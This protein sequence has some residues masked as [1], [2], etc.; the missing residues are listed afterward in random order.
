MLG[1]LEYIGQYTNIPI[2]LIIAIIV[3]FAISNLIGEILEFR[4]KVV[5]ELFKIR[6]YF[7][8]KK[9]ERETLAKMP[10]MMDDVHKLLNDVN[11][12][13][14]ADNITMRNKWIDDVNY[15]LDN[16]ESVIKEI[17]SKIDVNSEDITNLREDIIDLLADN[18]REIIISFAEK[19]VDDDFPVTRE[20]FGRIDR[21]YQEYERIINERG[22]KNGEVDVAH[23]IIEEAYQYRLVNHSFIEDV[24][25][26]GLEQ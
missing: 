15:R 23:K 1:Y 5:P 14:S 9:Q 22:I 24:R 7:A 8:R 3:F 16:H 17:N 6:K 2:G 20:Q 10:E 18:K 4:G 26:H 13:Y 11:Q 19:V 25:W 21:V 12:H